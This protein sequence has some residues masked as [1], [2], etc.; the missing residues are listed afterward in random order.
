MSGEPLFTVDVED[1]NHALHI[2]KNGHTSFRS[3]LWLVGKLK[4]YKIEAVFYVLQKFEE[5]FPE[6]P[7][8]LYLGGHQ[9]YSHG[10]YHI[11]GEK[12]DRQPYAFLGLCG[13]FWLR[14]LPYNMLKSQIL[15]E[16]QLYVHPHD[17]D[18]DHPK[19][20]NPVMN[21]KR[22]IGLKTARTKLER[23][24]SEIRWASPF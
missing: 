3:F 14:V 17:L 13:G 20:S 16:G 24:M 21:W 1:W 5:E 10:K 23:L 19:L 18:E 2:P 22:H 9:I 8:F 4:E 15:K 11:R 12:S 7:H 6:I